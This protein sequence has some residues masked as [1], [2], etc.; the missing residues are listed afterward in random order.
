MFLALYMY[1]LLTVISYRLN[2]FGYPN[3]AALDGRHLNPGL[4]DHRKAVEWVFN[5]ISAFGGDPDRMILFGQSAGYGSSTLM[6][7]SLL[8]VLVQWVSTSMHTP[9]LLTPL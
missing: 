3:A 7:C 6:C 9:T 5:H 8:I 2:I 1:T 4:L